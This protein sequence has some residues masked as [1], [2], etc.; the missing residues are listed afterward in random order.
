MI[1]LFEMRSSAPASPLMRE[2]IIA[3]VFGGREDCDLSRVEGD[4]D[5]DL[6][7]KDGDGRLDE[8]HG[9]K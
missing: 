4:Q 5:I 9:V 3:T 7:E 6:Y 8:P 1:H 2:I